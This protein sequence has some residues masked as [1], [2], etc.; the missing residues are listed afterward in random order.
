M[1]VQYFTRLVPSFIWLKHISYLR[2]EITLT[3]FLWGM[4]LAVLRTVH[5]LE[6][7]LQQKKTLWLFLIATTLQ[8]L[9]SYH[10][11]MTFPH[12]SDVVSL[13]AELALQKESAYNPW[14]RVTPNLHSECRTFCSHQEL[15][16]SIRGLSKPVVILRSGIR[17]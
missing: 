13:Q 7:E 16:L 12:R 10:L 17:S 15:L 6:S 1:F 5:R 2:N 4:S 3:G 8:L 11:A 14:M 9:L